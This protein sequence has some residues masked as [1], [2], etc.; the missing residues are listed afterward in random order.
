MTHLKT[1]ARTKTRHE[2]GQKV[3]QQDRQKLIQQ[4]L[5]K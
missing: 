3:E 2:D 1:T 4:E 5:P